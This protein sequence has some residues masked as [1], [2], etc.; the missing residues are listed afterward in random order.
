MLSMVEFE[1]IYRIDEAAH[2]DRSR[3]EWWPQL[4]LLGQNVLAYRYI[5]IMRDSIY[6]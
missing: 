1:G 2:M 4:Y 3:L 6:T 5:E